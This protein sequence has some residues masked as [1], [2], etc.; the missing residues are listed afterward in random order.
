M[1]R[2]LLSLTIV[3]TVSPAFA[4]GISLRRINETTAMEDFPVLVRLHRD[5]F[6]FG[7]SSWPRES[8]GT[9][10]SCKSEAT[11]R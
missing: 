4:D 11:P 6:D 8:T 10:M 1:N 5:F 7:Q 9:R 2:W 3:L